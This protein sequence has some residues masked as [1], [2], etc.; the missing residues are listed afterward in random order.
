[1]DYFYACRERTNKE[2]LSSGFVFRV[3]K[4][5]TT[6]SPVIAYIFLSGFKFQYL[7]QV[8]NTFWTRVELQL[9]RD[10]TVKTQYR[11]FETNI[12]EKELRG[13]SPNP[14]FMFL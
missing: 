3:S 2:N 14:T 1:M 13:H 7:Y 6:F 9:R 11:K 5:I 10:Y 8:I 4:I 12:P